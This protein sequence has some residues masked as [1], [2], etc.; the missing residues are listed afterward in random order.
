MTYV[1]FLRAGAA[2]WWVLR[3]TGAGL[4]LTAV[5]ENPEAADV[6]GISVA[7]HPVRRSSSAGR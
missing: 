3:S 2:V 4:R 6:A 7:A 5:G 1:A